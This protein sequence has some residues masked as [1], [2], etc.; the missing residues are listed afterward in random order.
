MLLGAAHS[1]GSLVTSIKYVML[2]NT[3]PP[4][5]QGHYFIGK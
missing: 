4:S 1:D 2:S 5:P 3:K